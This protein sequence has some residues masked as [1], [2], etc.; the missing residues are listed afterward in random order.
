MFVNENQIEIE[1]KKL[2]KLLVLVFLLL[3]NLSLWAQNAEY[4]RAA[5]IRG[6]K[7]A[8][9][10]LGCL[11]YLGEGLAKD[12]QQAVYWFTK[13][14][15]QG[16]VVAQYLLGG[17]YYNGEGVVQD[18][19]Q[20]VYWYTKAAN[21]DYIA[22]QNSL[23]VCYCHGYG[24]PQDSKKAVYWFNKAANQGNVEAQ[25]N[26]GDCYYNGSGVPQDNKQ[27]IYWW[28]KAANQGHANAQNNL[29]T[30]YSDGDGVPQDYKQAVYWYTKAANQG[31]AMAQYNLGRQYEKGE[32]VTKDESQAVFW[33]RKAA[34]QDLAQAQYQLGGCY[35]LG[36]GVEKNL[37]LARSWY[38]KAKDNP[39][40]GDR[41][42]RMA[43][44]IIGSIDREMS[45]IGTTTSSQP[46]QNTSTSNK[47]TTSSSTATQPQPSSTTSSSY[48]SNSSTYNKYSRWPLFYSNPVFGFR[49]GY[50]QRAFRSKGSVMDINVDNPPY[51]NV[52]GEHGV[53]NGFQA[54]FFIIPSRKNMLTVTFGLNY[55]MY[56]CS[57][58]NAQSYSREYKEINLYAPFD[59][60]FHVPFSR[61]SALYVHGGLGF[62]YSCYNSY[63]SLERNEYSRNASDKFNIS[64]E[65]GLDLKIQGL[66]L[67]ANFQKGITKRYLYGSGN[68]MELDKISIGLAFGF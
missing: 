33:Y 58:K 32:G 34:E 30:C 68:P 65:C 18:Y 45:E 25:C 38:V 39:D 15:N 54:G 2:Q 48:S 27:A 6:D 60:S 51:I 44:F 23:G 20:A 11:F 50:A 37:K 43:D 64:W 66:I 53:M 9:C 26:F 62:D 4:Y 24:V 3:A 61:R 59:L 5:A 10:K 22:A 21:Q 36:K 28:T 14:A 12:Y 56:F 49:F 42:K 46:T 16:V 7:E 17:C 31:N 19:K 35:W 29:G 55:E 63:S 13:S 40:L 8:Q 41:D 67:Y 1:M 47:P 57:V 52:F